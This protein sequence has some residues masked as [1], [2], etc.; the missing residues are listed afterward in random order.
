MGERCPVFNMP[1]EELDNL[2]ERDACEL[3]GV[4]PDSEEGCKLLGT[5]HKATVDTTTTGCESD[6]F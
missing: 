6:A 4:D 5:E 3:M 1:D 2:S